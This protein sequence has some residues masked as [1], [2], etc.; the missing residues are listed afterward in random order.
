MR[1]CSSVRISLLGEQHHFWFSQQSKLQRSE[2]KDINR[3]PLPVLNYIEQYVAY[4][5]FQSLQQIVNHIL[6]IV[7]ITSR[8]LGFHVFGIPATTQT[9]I[10]L[11]TAPVTNAIKKTLLCMYEIYFSPSLDGC[12]TGDCKHVNYMET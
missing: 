3:K 1:I 4:I 12:L 8:H 11:C 9:F 5:S 2:R 7:Q 6:K 10:A